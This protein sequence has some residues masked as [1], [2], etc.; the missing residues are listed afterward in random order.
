VKRPLKPAEH[1]MLVEASRRGIA[2]A[3]RKLTDVQKQAI[4][5][6]HHLKLIEVSEMGMF[7]LAT[8]AG[9]SALIREDVA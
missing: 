7:L 6:L 3:G 9:R 4:K 5:A 2:L 8:E 1:N